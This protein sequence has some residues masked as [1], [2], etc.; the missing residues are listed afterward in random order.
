M[1]VGRGFGTVAGVSYA[2]AAPLTALQ[3]RFCLMSKNR[4]WRLAFPSPT[5]KC[6]LFSRCRCGRQ[7]RGAFASVAVLT[8]RTLLMKFP[9]AF[10]PHR[11]IKKLIIIKDEDWDH[12]S[13]DK[14]HYNCDY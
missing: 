3:P 14:L 4:P 7:K 2:I 6:Q 12:L 9:K 1:R 13:V 5:V 8:D 10:A 11:S